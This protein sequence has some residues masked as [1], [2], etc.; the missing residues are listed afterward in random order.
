L[1]AAALTQRWGRFIGPGLMPHSYGLPFQ[2]GALLSLVENKAVLSSQTNRDVEPL[3]SQVE[4]GSAIRG[5]YLGRHLDD[6]LLSTI[7]SE[8][9]I[10]SSGNAANSSV[11]MRSPPPPDR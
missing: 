10:R 3:S 5:G 8:S 4:K 2:F 7:F 11:A 6:K 1:A 9:A